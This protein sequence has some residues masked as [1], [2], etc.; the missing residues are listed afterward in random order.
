MKILTALCLL[1]CAPALFAQS[2]KPAPLSP[3]QRA[4]I[5][6]A[7]KLQMDEITRKLEEANAVAQARALERI[8]RMKTNA[9]VQREPLEPVRPKTRAPYFNTNA[10]YQG[11][12]LDIQMME[13]RI[14]GAST[15]FTPAQR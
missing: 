10:W 12:G 14:P 13:K 9:P 5:Q 7:Q 8:A 4:V 1:A 6:A 11:L 15:N 3:E 2:N